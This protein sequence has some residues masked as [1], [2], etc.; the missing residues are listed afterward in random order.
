MNCKGQFSIIAALLVAVVLVAAVMATYSAI[1]YSPVQEQP[2]ILSA[3]DETNLGI[4][5]LL[6]FT[7]GYYGSVLE[8]TGNVTYAQQ[9]AISYLRSGLNSLNQIRPEWGTAFNLTSLAVGASWFSNQSYSE[10]SLSVNYNLTGLGIYGVSYSTSTRLDVQISPANQTNQAQLK[11][12]RDEGQ[13]LLNLG[14]SN[15]Q[16]YRYDY[17]NSTWQLADPA[18]I[19][20]YADGT[21]LL[22]LPDGVSGNAYNIQVKDTRGLMVVAASFSQ[23]TSTL[24]WNST[25]MDLYPDVNNIYYVDNNSSHVDG[26][27]NRARKVILMPKKI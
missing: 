4:K 7:V 15:L 27:P 21:Y 14:K 13:P 10:G 20:S 19:A 25:N 23:F 3:I 8:V 17:L 12:L 9:L 2:Q 6:G 11:I 1:R 22:D 24:T 16:L 5:E 26:S 18:N